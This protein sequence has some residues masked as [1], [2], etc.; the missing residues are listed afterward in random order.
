M[1]TK[2]NV[3]SKYV[4]V[5]LFLKKL[6]FSYP[7]FTSSLLCRFGLAISN[8]SACSFHPFI[9]WLLNCVFYLIHY[10]KTIFLK[11][12]KK[13]VFL[14]EFSFL[15]LLLRAAPLVYGSS[16]AR[17]RIRAVVS[18]LHW[19]Q[20]NLGSQLHLQPIPRLMAAL[21]PWPT[22]RGQGSILMDTS[23]IHF[24]WAAMGTPTWML[25]KTLLDQ[26]LSWLLAT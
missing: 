9:M 22:K 17:G 13:H 2:H 16:Q 10:P 8:L 18:G 15:F 14:P 12:P 19:S 7:T 4:L 11:V 3:F 5:F 6:A 21:D 24:W 23:Q 1:K 26:T 25:I 20:S